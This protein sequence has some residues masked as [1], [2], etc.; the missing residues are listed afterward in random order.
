MDVVENMD[1]VFTIN[2][3]E[4][5]TNDDSNEENTITPT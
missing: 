1:C 2:N 4:D 3:T 5:K